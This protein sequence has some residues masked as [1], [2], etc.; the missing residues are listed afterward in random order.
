MEN[1]ITKI[2]SRDQLPALL[3]EFGLTGLGAEGGVGQGEYSKAIL[4]GSDLSRLYSIDPL[5][6]YELSKYRD[7][8]NLSQERHDQNWRLTLETL[9]SFG[10]RSEIWRLSSAEAVLRFPDVSLDFIYI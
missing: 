1:I 4:E 7:P 6:K 3:R 5:H 2:S 8:S 10:A 9:A